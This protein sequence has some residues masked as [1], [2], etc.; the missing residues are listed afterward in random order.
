M[1]TIHDRAA[2]KRPAYFPEIKEL[3]KPPKIRNILP[4]QMKD[5]YSEGKINAYEDIDHIKHSPQGYEAKKNDPSILFYRTDFNEKAGF[6]TISTGILI[7][8]QLHVRLQC[9]GLPISLPKWFSEGRTSKF[10]RFSMLAN[11]PAYLAIHAKDNPSG[12]MDELRRRQNCSPKGRPP[13]SPEPLR[14]SL[15]LRYT[16]PQTY[17]LLLEQLIPFSVLLAA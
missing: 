10:E 15:L 12:I 13:F 6:P 9:D 11:F 5:F 7:D 16:S 2:M 8:S 3:R 4:D 14:Y 1:P 17:R